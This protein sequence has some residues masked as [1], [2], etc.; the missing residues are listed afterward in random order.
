MTNT[1]CTDAFFA[2][3]RFVAE[4]RSNIKVNIVEAEGSKNGFM[5]DIEWYSNDHSFHRLSVQEFY[6]DDGFLV[7]GVVEYLY[8][9]SRENQYTR[10]ES[11]VS[12]IDKVRF[13]PGAFN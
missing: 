8:S 11:A 6:N 10:Y 12:S 3:V 4:K 1:P 7:E 5:G 13:E 9:V 2:A